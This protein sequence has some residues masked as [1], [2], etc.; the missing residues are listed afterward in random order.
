MTKYLQTVRTRA[1]PGVP[2]P[3]M[4]LPTTRVEVFAGVSA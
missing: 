3:P 1:L 2:G 4:D